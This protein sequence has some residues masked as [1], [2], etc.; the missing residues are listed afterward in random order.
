MTQIFW[1]ATL[2]KGA[3]DTPMNIFPREPFHFLDK[4]LHS[5]I[6][7]NFFTV[8][9]KRTLRKMA[10]TT[11]NPLN[12]GILLWPKIGPGLENPGFA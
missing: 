3:V 4:K 12:A 2:R 11:E 9:F 6:L 8:K 10:V 1:K 7:I 5:K